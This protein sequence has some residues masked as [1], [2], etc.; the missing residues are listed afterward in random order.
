MK[1]KNESSSGGLKYASQMWAVWS[2]TRKR[3]SCQRYLG[4]TLGCTHLDKENNIDLRKKFNV[5]SLNE[6]IK[7]IRVAICKKFYGID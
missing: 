6:T 3:Y 2:K 7:R 5:T 4:G 1:L